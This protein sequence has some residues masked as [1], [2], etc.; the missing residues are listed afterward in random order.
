LEAEPWFSVQSI[1][2]FF[3][4]PALTAHLHLTT[5]LNM[6]SR[7]FKWVPHFLD[8]DLEAKRL[9]GVRQL[10]NVLQAEEKCQLRDLI[11]GDETWVYLDMKPGTIRLPADAELSVRVKRTIASEKGMGIVCWG[12]HGIAHY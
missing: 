8:D 7:H 4:I 10:L 2:E 12:I 3:K 5:S 11:R 9:D 1:A 6:K